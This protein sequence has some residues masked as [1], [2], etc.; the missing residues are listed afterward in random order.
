M[1][2]PSVAIFSKS[3]PSSGARRESRLRKIP[4]PGNRCCPDFQCR[5]ECSGQSSVVSGQWSVGRCGM[6]E[7]R[8]RASFAL[9]TLLQFRVLRKVIGRNLDG[10][11]TFEPGIAGAVNLAHAAGTERGLDFVR[12]EFGARGERHSSVAAL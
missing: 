6:V 11:G 10:D 7:R 5:R 3:E 9:E 12:A 8:N 4:S 2:H 1:G